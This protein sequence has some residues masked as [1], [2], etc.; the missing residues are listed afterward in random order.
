MTA[1]LAQYNK[2]WAALAGIAL[3]LLFRHLNIELPGL[4]A[5]VLDLIIGGL[6]AVAV[7][8]V[9]NKPRPQPSIHEY[10]EGNW[11]EPF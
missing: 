1:F 2:L 7:E 9:P 11:T 6:T 8:R 3:L 10:E 5:A 4:N